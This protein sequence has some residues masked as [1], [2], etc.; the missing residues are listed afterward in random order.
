MSEGVPAWAHERAEVHPYDPQWAARASIK[1]QRLTELL[2]PWMMAAIEHVGSTA[3]PGLAAKPIIDLAANVANPDAVAALAAEALA[4]DGWHYVP[5]ELDGR[6]WRRFFV[7]PD[8]SGQHREAHLHLI[9]AE[10][11]R[12]IEQIAFRDALR[13]DQV[14]ARRYEDLKRQLADRYGNDREAYTNGKAV[15]VASVLGSSD[16]PGSTD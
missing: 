8:A 9:E 13:R 16:R 1:L 3:I 11:P 5:P 14:L 7:K 6:P 4:V 10:H 15:F 12:W 2:G